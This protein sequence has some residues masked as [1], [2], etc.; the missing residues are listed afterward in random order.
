MIAIIYIMKIYEK[1]YFEE[2]MNKNASDK[3][4][5]FNQRQ[6]G[7]NNLIILCEFSLLDRSR[8]NSSERAIFWACLLKTVQIS[9]RKKSL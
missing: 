4:A 5:I 3:I 9:S 8:E 6:V 1:I 2:S 7:L